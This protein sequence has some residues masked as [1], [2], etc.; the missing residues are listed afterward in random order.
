MNGKGNDPYIL[1]DGDLYH[2]KENGDVPQKIFKYKDTDGNGLSN[3]YPGDQNFCPLACTCAGVWDGNTQGYE[4]VA[5]G[6]CHRQG[7]SGGNV[8]DYNVT[9]ITIGINPNVHDE[10]T[11]LPSGIIQEPGKAYDLAY[12]DNLFFCTSKKDDRQI[13]DKGSISNNGLHFPLCNMDYSA[14]EGGVAGVVAKF[15]S[16]FLTYCDPIVECI[17]QAAPYYK[18]TE[19]SCA[20]NTGFTES[21]SMSK[22]VTESNE[23]S[24]E[25]GY[26]TSFKYSGIF[27]NLSTKQ[28]KG[29]IESYGRKF[30]EKISAGRDLKKAA[31]DK[32][33]VVIRRYPFC[34][35]DYETYN[36]STKNWEQNVTN[37]YLK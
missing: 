23:V 28:S 2:W 14:E 11:G 13:D 5:F 18:G 33:V 9:Y 15:T 21:Y 27:L 32:N 35:Y 4:Q 25:D 20:G 1:M 3:Y 36:P 12:S 10:N 19:N 29:S 17:L 31:T 8:D 16:S 6:L 22:E 37:S 30:S 7:G 26:G 34:M 24:E